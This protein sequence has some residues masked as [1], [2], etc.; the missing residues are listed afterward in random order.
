MRL[1]Q[2][3]KQFFMEMLRMEHQYMLNNSQKWEFLNNRLNK[4]LE[5]IPLLEFINIGDFMNK[6]EF[7]QEMNNTT[8]AALYHYIKVLEDRV[9]K[10]E[11]EKSN[12]A[13]VTTTKDNDW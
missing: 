12:G 7:T 2:V 10:L 9:E 13:K 3:S 5:Q 1:Q 4:Y 8:M 6:Q 11:K